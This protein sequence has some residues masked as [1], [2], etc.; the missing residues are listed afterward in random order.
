MVTGTPGMECSLHRTAYTLAGCGRTTPT[1]SRTGTVS[2]GIRVTFLRGGPFARYRSLREL[3]MIA[4]QTTSGLPAVFDEHPRRERH[5]GLRMR[6]LRSAHHPFTA[7][8]RMAQ[9]ACALPLRFYKARPRPVLRG[10]FHD[11]QEALPVCR[12]LA[13]YR[14]R[15]R[16]VPT[17]H[18]RYATWTA[19]VENTSFIPRDIGHRHARYILVYAKHP[20]SLAACSNGNTS[21]VQS[22]AAPD[23]QG[24]QHD[25]PT[26]KTKT[27]N[28]YRGY[29]L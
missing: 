9:L 17:M 22:Q 27:R 7:Y 1:R 24:L 21:R 11:H 26:V 25:S 23:P 6:G 28:H 16:V 8:T 19:T 15:I 10:L 13:T 2:G 29:G 18:Y 20:V 12:S 14:R 4:E 5:C 3:M